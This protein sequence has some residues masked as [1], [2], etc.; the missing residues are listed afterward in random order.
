MTDLRLADERLC[1]LAAEVLGRGGVFELRAR[2]HSM[3]PYIADGD[4]VVLGKLAEG[5]PLL[6]DVV[7]ARTAAGLRLHR[8]VSRGEVVRLR[9]DAEPGRGE[10]VAAAD[11]LGRVVAV[12]VNLFQ[13]NLRR[14]RALVRK[15]T[16]WTH[17]G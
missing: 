13:R 9:G 6:G 4:R 12:R 10:P 17:R 5:G 7:L 11:V 15:L 16:T 8:V 1:D 3:Y 2:G 14:L